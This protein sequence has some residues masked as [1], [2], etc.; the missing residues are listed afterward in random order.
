MDEGTIVASGTPRE[1]FAQIANLRKWGLEAPQITETAL[2]I[3]QKVPRL[4]KKIPLK[5]EELV[6]ELCSFV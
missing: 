3:K 1:V 2:L 4:F 6:D 5:K